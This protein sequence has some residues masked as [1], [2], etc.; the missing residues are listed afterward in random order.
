MCE[1]YV[2]TLGYLFRDYNSPLAIAYFFIFGSFW[3]SFLNVC[4]Y[5][6]PYGRSIVYPGS[7]CP[8]CG[9]PI[10][11]WQNIPVLS[12]IIIKAQCHCCHSKI[13]FRYPLIELT[14]AIICAFLFHICRG[15]GWE[16]VYSFLFS[17]LLIVIFFI[18][19]DHWLILDNVIMPGVIIGLVGSLWI[20]PRDTMGVDFPA[21]VQYLPFNERLHWNNLIDSLIGMGAGYIFFAVIA[22]M[23]SIILRQEAMG[24]GD[25]KFAALI[26]AFLGC[27]GSALA[28]ILSFF[29]GFFYALPLLLIKRKK[30]K[31][32][33]PFGTF[34]AIAAFLTLIWHEKLL[35]LFL[36]WQVLFFKTDSWQ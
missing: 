6:L 29:L 19:L 9:Q 35:W 26:G 31:D 5:R 8:R 23:G 24:G 17:N 30:G 22:L 12:Y 13:S 1:D 20:L 2:T 21:L 32:P 11:W 36:N 18:D 3:G 28:F 10:E 34:M 14:T 7:S 16:F 33:V 15:F 27:K 25:V 4:I